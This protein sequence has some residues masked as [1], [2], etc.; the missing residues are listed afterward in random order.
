MIACSVFVFFYIEFCLQNVG[1]L[2]LM[3]LKV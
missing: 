3:Q 2:G 1:I